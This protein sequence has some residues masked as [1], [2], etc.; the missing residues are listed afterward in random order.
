M[1]NEIGAVSNNLSSIKHEASKALQISNTKAEIKQRL[2]TESLVKKDNGGNKHIS[3]TT[4]KNIVNDM[5][6][7]S[8][9]AQKVRFAYSGKLGVLYVKII[10]VETNQVIGQIPPK[11]LLRLEENLREI[12]GLIID[13]TQ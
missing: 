8:L 1:H 5:N 7:N 13:K 6:S 12:S 3:D 4:I 2:Q 9:L 11:S 10:D